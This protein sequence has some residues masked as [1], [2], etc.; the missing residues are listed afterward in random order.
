M[1][2]IAEAAGISR[3]ALYLHFKSRTD[4]M[5]AT[6]RYIDEVKGL[7]ERLKQFQKAR[8]GTELLDVC[9]D[10][11]G[12]YIPEIYGVVRAL[13]MTRATDE[14]TAA[15]WNECM[16]G[17]REICKEIIATLIREGEY[18]CHKAFPGHPERLADVF[19]LK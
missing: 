10:V 19:A 17:L 8:S 16:Q 7:N 4:L 2:D 1:S 15:A 5:I 11:W 13:L 12:N 18:T 14:D 6:T 3:Q 9:I